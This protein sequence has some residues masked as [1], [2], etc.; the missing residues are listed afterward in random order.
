MTITH[1]HGVMKGYWFEEG[2]IRTSGYEFDVENF[3]REI[4]LTN[5]AVQKYTP[6]YGRF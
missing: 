5:D 6:N 1:I 4:H 3:E 2:Y